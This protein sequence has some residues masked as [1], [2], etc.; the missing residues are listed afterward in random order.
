MRVAEPP[1]PPYTMSDLGQ[2]LRRSAPAAS[3]NMAPIEAVLRDWLPPSGLVLEVASG[4]GEHALAFARA[5]PS[6]VWQPSDPDGDALASIAA[7]RSGGPA[8]LLAPLFL[9][10]ASSEWP[11]DRAEA[12]LNVNMVHIA[13]PAAARGLLDGAARLLSTDAPLILYG[14]WLEQG[15]EPASSNIAFDAS[16][17]ARNPAWGL[18]TVEEFADQA[19][20]RGLALEERRAM[21]SNNLMLR[22]VKR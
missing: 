5:F 3:R 9:D 18:R 22:F 6:L 10:A 14:P 11:L 16:L 20:V 15:V 7:W 17:K 1:L 12:I 4:T 13:P 2:S 8:N 21:P 19:A